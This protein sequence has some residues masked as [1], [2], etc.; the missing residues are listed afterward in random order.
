MCLFRAGRALRRV[1]VRELVLP[2]A[3]ARDNELFRHPNGTGAFF[4]LPSAAQHLPTLMACHLPAP[5]QRLFRA[6]SAPA[7]C[8]IAA[9][10]MALYAAA[11]S[12]DT[13]F[14]RDTRLEAAL[15]EARSSNRPQDRYTQYTQSVRLTG[16]KRKPAASPLPPAAGAATASLTPRTGG[17]GVGSVTPCDVDMDSCVW[18]FAGGGTVHCPGG[19]AC[20]KA[21]RHENWLL[22]DASDKLVTYLPVLYDSGEHSAVLLP[23]ADPRVG[24][25]A[26]AR[27]G[28][29]GPVVWFRYE[30]ESRGGRRGHNFWDWGLGEHLRQAVRDVA[31]EELLRLALG[32]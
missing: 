22:S 2:Q 30:Y 4:F 13:E 7:Q 9:R 24:G 23:L 29:E 20:R 16:K 15:T 31:G 18:A 11:A 28:V 27:Q 1:A 12:P 19:V 17:G 25:A 32:A 5:L 10:A 8:T 3:L 14:F 6:F 21:G 26:P